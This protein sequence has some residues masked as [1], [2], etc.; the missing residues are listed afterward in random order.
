MMIIVYY[1][2]Y[3][4]YLVIF[5]SY[6]VVFVFVV[7]AVIHVWKIQQTFPQGPP[8]IDFFVYSV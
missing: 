8:E 2:T 5:V 3:F 4:V 6:H 1:L 7:V